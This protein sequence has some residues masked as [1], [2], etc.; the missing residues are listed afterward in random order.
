MPRTC[1]WCA[2]A[3]EIQEGRCPWCRQP[4]GPPPEVAALRREGMVK[5]IV[6]ACLIV[7][8]PAWLLGTPLWLWFGLSL[9]RRGRR[10]TGRTPAPAWILL[11]V[12]TLTSL[13]LAV[14]ATVITFVLIH[15]ANR[16]AE[17]WVD[18]GRDEPLVVYV[19][20]AQRVQV[21]ADRHVRIEVGKGSRTLEARSK[22]GERVASWTGVLESRGKYLFC[23]GATERYRRTTQWYGDTIHQP[24]DEDYPRSEWL[25]LKGVDFVLQPLPDQIV[26]NNRS[27]DSRVGV[28]RGDPTPVA[29][30][31]DN[32]C[33]H[34]VTVS[35]DG[36]ETFALE[37]LEWRRVPLVEGPHRIVARG[38]GGAALADLTRTTSPAR[39]YLVSLPGEGEYVVWTSSYGRNPATV[40]DDRRSLVPADL[41][42]DVTEYHSIFETMPATVDLQAHETIVERKGLF[43]PEDE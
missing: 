25:D 26:L 23:P 38:V 21:A 3:V 12:G 35:I 14:I 36:G 27:F 2:E 34:G 43:R 29:L 5:A 1:P 42:M 10:L 11:G 41:W 13:I 17:I 16:P 37:P 40:P 7:F 8:W 22:T 19:D 15:E 39:K 20:G 4:I 33:E 28:Y 18:N 9:M 6:S 30:W 24:T 32:R 31:I